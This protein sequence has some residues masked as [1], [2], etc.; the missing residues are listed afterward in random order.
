M[1]NRNSSL[2][3]VL[4][5]VLL[6]GCG[7][8][9]PL[10]TPADERLQNQ[11]QSLEATGDYRTAA[12]VYLQAAAAAAAPEKYRLQL[13]AAG[14]LI[15]G[16]ALPEAEALLTSLE[17]A[18]LEGELR[19]HYLVRRAALALAEQHPEQVL[20]LLQTPPE[21]PGLRSE[22][23][24]L[25]A[26]ALQQNSQF[27]P[28]AR[29]RIQ[30][31]A[32]L[33]DP[34]RR[35]AN[36]RALWDALNSLSDTELQRL[37]TAPPPDPLSGWMELVELTRL[38]LQQPET[39]AEVI[40][41]WQQRYPEHPASRQF[42]ARLLDTMRTAGQPP[43]QVAALLPLHGDL[44]EVAGAIR[45]G[46]I[47][48]YY[49]TPEGGKRPVLRLY[50]SGATPEQAI[51]AYRQAVSEGARFV[52]G[53]LRKESVEALA[54]LQPLEVPVLGLNQSEDPAL[55]NPNLFQF[56]LAPEDEAREVARLAWRNGLQRAV[57][58]LPDNEWGERVYSA[59]AQEWE[60]LGG[61]VVETGRYQEGDADHGDVISAL[62]NLDASKARH[63]QLTRLLGTRLEFEPR[64]RQD[65]D[66]VFL[67]A[68]PRQAR[69]IR[70]QLSFYHASRLPVYATS[71]VYTGMPDRARDSDMNGIIFCDMPWT[72]ESREN[73][74]HL[75]SAV[76]EFWPDSSGRYAR[77]YAL[78]IDAYRV[79]PYLG[80]LGNNMPGAYHGVTGNLSLGSG[81]RVNRTLRCARFAEG[82]A[83]LL[84]QTVPDAAD[85][86]GGMP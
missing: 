38:Y 58:L 86:S 45:D 49:E 8:M 50:D 14:S 56:G 42:I 55:M 5:A 78:G 76:A 15:R 59:F 18:G 53:P 57:A 26:A 31:D 65:I 32:L 43:E 52:I 40:P 19:Q 20:T 63:Q 84:E 27:L 37:R 23:H 75:Q 71:R 29:E 13:L 16:D 34:E 25:R 60:L 2:L 39:L 82:V 1:I 21:D 80:E 51:A 22:Y 70:P 73:W 68:S 77:L 17:T 69:L 81:G 28:S 47:A 4:L 7:G 9:P 6:A 41:H 33:T 35:L 36:Q 74:S 11:V 12:Q 46:M 67:I 24:E 72:L 10:V 62:L 83:E 54:R 85:D 48:A 61:Q 44:A 30:L 66:F 64:R 3:A 79:I